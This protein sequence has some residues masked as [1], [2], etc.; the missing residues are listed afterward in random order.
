MRIHLKKKMLKPSGWTKQVDSVYRRRNNPSASRLSRKYLHCHE[1][2][3]AIYELNCKYQYNYSGSMG[4]GEVELQH[5][6]S[7]KQA[8]IV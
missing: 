7:R 8:D 5:Y 1:N 3:N 2:V 4:V 6:H